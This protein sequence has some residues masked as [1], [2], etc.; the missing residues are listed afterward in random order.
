MTNTLSM[1]G[2]RQNTTVLASPLLCCTRTTGR[3]PASLSIGRF[4]SAIPDNFPAK[5]LYR[6]VAPWLYV[7]PW[8]FTQLRSALDAV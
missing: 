3:A 4:G 5:A 6:A 8:F 1:L 7:E 2:V